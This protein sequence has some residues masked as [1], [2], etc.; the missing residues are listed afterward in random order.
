MEADADE[1]ILRRIVRD[2]EERGRDLKGIITQY[3]TTVKPMHYIY[4]EPTRALADI[5]I[6][7]GKN[8]VAFDLFVSK[9]GQLLES[10]GNKI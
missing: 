5:V 7:S 1:R 10:A 3:L 4:V 6:N 2:V 9:I 8:D